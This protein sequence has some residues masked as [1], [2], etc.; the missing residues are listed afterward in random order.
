MSLIRL[1]EASKERFIYHVWNKLEDNPESVMYKTNYKTS[2]LPSAEVITKWVDSGAADKFLKASNFNWQN[3]VAGKNDENGVPLYITLLNA[4]FD[5]KSTG[6]SR[7][8]KYKYMKKNP[9][10][11]FKQSGLKVIESGEED[12]TADMMLLPELENDEFIFVVPLTYEACKFMDSFECGGAGAKWCLGYEKSSEYF[13]SYT[14]KGRLFILAFRKQTSAKDEIKY[15]IEL[16]NYNGA[17]AWRQDDDKDRTIPESQYK[18]MFGWSH[19][20][21]FKVFD[22]NI[23]SWKEGNVYLEGVRPEKGFEID[24]LFIGLYEYEHYMQAVYENHELIF[25]GNDKRHDNFDIG[26]MIDFINH[27]SEKPKFILRIQNGSFKHLEFTSEKGYLP[28]NVII[29]DDVSV[30]EMDCSSYVFHNTR[31]IGDG[32]QRMYV[33]GKRIDWKEIQEV[34]ST[35]RNRLE[36]ASKARFI[37]RVWN[38]LE[39]DPEEV[40]V[41]V[42]A[43]PNKFPSREAITKWVDS[44]AADKFLKANNFNWQKFTADNSD[45]G[46]PLY[47]DLISAYLDYVSSGGSNKEK[48]RIQK[49]DPVSIFE[50]NT[51][52]LKVVHEGDT[53][54][55]ADMVIM[56]SFEN[57][58]WLFV[59]PMTHKA[60][61]FMNSFDCGGQGAKW[62]IGTEDN[63]EPWE[64][65][66]RK[67]YEWFVLA[68]NKEPDCAENEK[69]CMIQLQPGLKL[70]DLDTLE[71]LSKGYTTAKIWNQ[72]DKRSDGGSVGAHIVETLQ[73]RFKL[74]FYPFLKAFYENIIQKGES[75][76]LTYG[77]LDAANFL[78][79]LR[80]GTL[81]AQDVV[82]QSRF[83]SEFIHLWNKQVPLKSVEELQDKIMLLLRCASDAKR[84][85]LA[86]E[87]QGYEFEDEDL[88]LDL[89][90]FNFDKAFEERG[91]VLSF[92]ECKLNNIYITTPNEDYIRKEKYADFEFTKLE[93]NDVNCTKEYTRWKCTTITEYLDVDIPKE[94][95]AKDHELVKKHRK[96]IEESLC[97]VLRVK[98]DEVLV[99][100]KIDRAFRKV[101]DSLQ[102]SRYYGSRR[103]TERARRFLMRLEEAS[104]ERFIKKVWS[105]LEADSDSVMKMTNYKTEGLPD[106]D[107]I[108]KWVDSG[109]AN[110]FL[111][112]VNFNWQNFA[113]G[114]NDKDDIPLYV[115]LLNAY[116]DYKNAGGSRKEKKQVMKE[117]PVLIFENNNKGL[118]VVHEGSDVTGADIV[119]MD[120]F[121][122]D[123]WIFVVPMSHKA[124]VFMDSFE[125]GGQGAKWC[126][127]TEGDSQYWENYTQE[128]EEWF[129]MVFN[130]DPACNENEKKYMIEIHSALLYW[131]FD[132]LEVF[133][134]NKVDFNIWNQKDDKLGEHIKES[135]LEKLGLPLYEF[136]K[137]FYKNI[138]QKGESGY[139][140]CC[141]LDEYAF[142]S[143]IRNKTLTAQDVKEYSK[144]SD[145]IQ[146]IRR[147][148][149]LKSVQDLQDTIMLILRCIS[150]SKVNLT[151]YVE[152][153][154]F[155][156]PEDGDLY[157]DLADFNFDKVIEKQGHVIRFDGC[158]LNSIYVTAPNENCIS[159]T[160]RDKWNS[161][162]ILT[163]LE[164]NGVN[165]TEDYISHVCY[166]ISEYLDNIIND[167]FAYEKSER[168]V[169]KKHR[170]TVEQAMCKSLRVGNDELVDCHKLQAHFTMARESLQKS[171][172]SRV[173]EKFINH[174]LR[175]DEA[176]KARFINTVWDELEDD[177]SAVM[178][179][180][181]VSANKFPSREEM[182]KW[183]DSGAAD[184]FLKASN[185]NWQKFVADNSDEIPLYVTLI[186]AYLD[187]KKAGGSNK[188]RRKILK[189]DPVQ[190]F[191]NNPMGLKV[192][193][194]G[195]NLSGADMLIAD[196][197]ENKE[198]LFVIPLSHKAC[199]FMDSFDC[200]GQ[201]AKWCIGQKNEPE[202]WKRYTK[203]HSWF[204]MAFNKDPFCEEDEKK[205]MLEL[206][207]RLEEINMRAKTPYRPDAMKLKIW[208]QEDSTVAESFDDDFE[209]SKEELL[210]YFID[211][212]IQPGNNRYTECITNDTKV[213]WKIQDGTLTPEDLK[214]Y[215]AK[216]ALIINPHMVPL[217]SVQELQDT[218]TKILHCIEDSGR[219]D[220]LFTVNCYN[221]S[222][223]EDGDFYLN[224][225]V[226]YA[227]DIK[228]KLSSSKFDYSMTFKSNR[229]NNVFIETKDLDFVDFD[230]KYASNDLTKIVINGKNYTRDYLS[231]SSSYPLSIT[232]FLDVMLEDGKDSIKTMIKKHR[233]E[234]EQFL[235][236]YLRVEV[237]EE[238]N[239]DV[240][241][242][243]FASEIK[244]RFGESFYRN[245][246]L[247]L[248]SRP[249]H[250]RIQEF[251]SERRG[252]FN[253]NFYR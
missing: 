33:D 166:T 183:V 148:I 11:V 77:P 99:S 53:V 234:I 184:K 58:D 44:G 70:W 120:S 236:E 206:E 155:D 73:E 137:S 244:S 81:T 238:I 225:D 57:D 116:F 191:E 142:I 30:D 113:A 161:F 188:E 21:M 14:E 242:E 202:Y 215:P 29:D 219:R 193:H 60:C 3:F 106:A 199:V 172:P 109:A 95:K 180:V 8:D 248:E 18:K 235:C 157:L 223:P 160:E 230:E 126:I 249:I 35:M 80:K 85:D 84:T 147:K 134:K 123:N 250:R 246:R 9:Y 218:I 136:L 87:I 51:W 68:F 135:F 7:K 27:G 209:F 28:Q 185:F 19:N 52:G 127:G 36:E 82:V 233:E 10:E 66:T 145:C 138:L 226:D 133:D 164:I 239:E 64:H 101:R 74:P 59:V 240:L 83:D 130:K 203:G 169:A 168:I 221:F 187:Y 253:E 78:N 5:Y 41:M 96:T 146:L 4:Y 43:D 12:T 220:I 176:S 204:V 165:R 103:M 40:M 197:L 217:K 170:K 20:E 48:K 111:Q 132:T 189:E 86:L 94:G 110:S 143:K 195:S 47:V 76:Y 175:L 32:I 124:C 26:G 22:K 67:L 75:E 156:K 139:L 201:G 131:N 159:K 100:Y 153:Y 117:D 128:K 105:G 13:K 50:K 144:T 227:L 6:G 49:E 198:W 177:P 79:K 38:E 192:V 97:N 25:N 252:R 179:M 140:A 205:Y 174:R 229:F 90:D 214:D 1:D 181:G 62:C 194:E 212:V 150:E 171:K 224:I 115:H 112:K 108:T 222:K 34:K 89:A 91:Y 247:R 154:A 178:S 102:E 104:K 162:R 92:V 72:E 23:L 186:S 151:L 213:I 2:F 24:K 208:D 15:M 69:K 121:E 63:S 54:T 211:N 55:G 231:N 56:D 31:I 88:N 216:T 39:K 163:K 245:S 17:E 152:L 241:Y 45:N 200:G 122:N 167:K 125:C 46:I 141:K 93:I 173:G 158:Y 71:I 251:K 118:K 149:D 129:V 182:T 196:S 210:A 190:I 119:I 65:Y 61:I 98:A 107:T 228:F 243:L 232:G 237:D 42:G 207:L 114:K 16:N 37:D